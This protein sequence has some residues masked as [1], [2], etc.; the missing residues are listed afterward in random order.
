LLL[1][2]PTRGLDVVSARTVWQRLLARR[3]SD[4]ALVFASADFD[5]LLAY[6]DMVLVF[7]AGQVSLPLPRAMLSETRLAEL[8]GGVGFEELHAVC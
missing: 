5:E 6:S 1:D 2:Q 8:I 4:T 3:S 7:Y